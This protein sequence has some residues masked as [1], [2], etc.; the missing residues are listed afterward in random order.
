MEKTALEL[1]I[2]ELEKELGDAEENPAPEEESKEDGAQ[3]E[4]L[5]SQPEPE[6]EPVKEPEPVKIEEPSVDKDAFARMRYQLSE[7]RR[8][9]EEL[10][11]MMQEKEQ[12]RAIPAK[13]EDYEGHVSARIE[14][15]EERLE[16]LEREYAET[17]RVNQQKELLDRATQEFAEYE[18]QFIAKAP[19]YEQARSHVLNSIAFSIK[20]LNPTITNA[21]LAEETAMALLKRG[22]V[23]VNQGMNPAEYIYHEARQM[24]YNPQPKQAQSEPSKPQLSTIAANKKKTANMAAATGSSGASY[25]VQDVLSM[26]NAEIS[27]LS[28]EDFMRLEEQAR[29][30]A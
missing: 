11:R 29:Q 2:E 25:G 5:T 24:G 26:S 12:L 7:E 20:T 6:H 18:S 1:S 17:K 4:E 27:R 19:D 30:R 8:K 15:A 9:R 14:T 16:R 28:E 23:A 22:A 13:D 3:Q 10:E 21:K